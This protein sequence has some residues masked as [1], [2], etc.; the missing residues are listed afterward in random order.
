M[1]MMMIVSVAAVPL[2]DQAAVCAYILL[3]FARADTRQALPVHTSL[4]LYVCPFFHL[5]RQVYSKTSSQRCAVCYKCQ[6]QLRV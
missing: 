4:S 1:M 2:M 6:L 3:W 5:L